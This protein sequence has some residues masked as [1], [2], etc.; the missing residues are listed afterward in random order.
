MEIRRKVTSNKFEFSNHAVEQFI[1]HQIQINEIKEVVA[2]GQLIRD[3]SNDKHNPSYLIFGLTQAQRPIH[4]KFS[5]Y[6]RPLIKII[7][8]YE[9]NPERWDNNFTMRRSHRNDE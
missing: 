6:T 3:Y 2:N 4:I 5:C 8:V 7:A 9:P 1:T